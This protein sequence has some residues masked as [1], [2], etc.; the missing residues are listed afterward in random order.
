MVV[1]IRTPPVSLPCYSDVPDTSVRRRDV[2][3]VSR[4]D[5]DTWLRERRVVIDGPFLNMTEGSKRYVMQE[6]ARILGPRRGSDLFGMTGRIVS[7]S[8]LLSLGASISPTSVR[9]GTAEYDLQMGC[10]V[11]RLEG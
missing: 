3:F 10:L 1:P 4:S 2:R 6:A 11:L 7:L 9:I 8:E 5:L